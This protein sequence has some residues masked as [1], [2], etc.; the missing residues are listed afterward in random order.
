M[1]LCIKTKK[2]PSDVIRCFST[3]DCLHFKSVFASWVFSLFSMTKSFLSMRHHHHLKVVFVCTFI[4]PKRT[5][6]QSFY[7]HNYSHFLSLLFPYIK[8]SGDWP[9]TVKLQRLDSAKWRCHEQH[10]RYCGWARCK[11]SH[12]HSHTQHLR[13]C[14]GS[15]HVVTVW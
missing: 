15:L 2:S 14:T 7:P 12:S 13:I 8:L 6:N 9:A 1:L 11:T 5:S 3:I 4:S 10:R